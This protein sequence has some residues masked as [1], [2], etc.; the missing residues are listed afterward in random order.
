MVAEATTKPFCIFQH[1]EV[2]KSQTVLLSQ[3]PYSAVTIHSRP[4]LP[5]RATTSTG[6][7]LMIENNEHDL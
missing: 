3:S 6:A 1:R 5:P 7:S 2:H 4:A